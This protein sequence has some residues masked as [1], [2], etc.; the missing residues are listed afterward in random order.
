MTT[1]AM[2]WRQFATK[3]AAEE[4][5]RGVIDAQP[6]DTPFESALLSD[7]ILERHYFCSRRGFQPSRYRK[8]GGYNEYAVEASFSAAAAPRQ[9]GWQSGSWTESLSPLESDWDRA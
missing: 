1:G 7:L 8:L 4:A 3:K 5:I 6:F 9:T 2:F